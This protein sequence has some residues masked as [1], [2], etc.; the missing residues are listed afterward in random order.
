M[1]QLF[2]LAIL[3]AVAIF[4]YLT[5]RR[6]ARRNS[7]RLRNGRRDSLRADID[8]GSRTDV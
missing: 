2:G 6:I 7:G 4:C 1:R 5:V 3:V 8:D